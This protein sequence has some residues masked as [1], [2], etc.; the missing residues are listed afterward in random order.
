MRPAQSDA[1]SSDEKFS[2]SSPIHREKTLSGLAAGAKKTTSTWLELPGL[3]ACRCRPWRGG[4]HPALA[5]ARVLAHTPIARGLVRT[6]ALAAIAADTLHVGSVRGTARGA[7]PK[8]RRSQKHRADR[9]RQNRTCNRFAIH[10]GDSPIR[11]CEGRR[12]ALDP[13]HASIIRIRPA[14]GSSSMTG[15]TISFAP[16]LVKSRP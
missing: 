16:S 2:D 13:V 8:D 6:L 14:D 15:S 9:R 1:E 3:R 12:P 7:L 4:R 11:L 10:R 5:L